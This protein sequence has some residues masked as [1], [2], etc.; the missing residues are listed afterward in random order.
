MDY[1]LGLVGTK[2][3]GKVDELDHETYVASLFHHLF[4]IPLIFKGTYL[5]VADYPTG[6]AGTKIIISW[7]SVLFAYL[8]TLLFIPVIFGILAIIIAL[9]DRSWG[10]FGIALQAIVPAW[11]GFIITY[12]LGEASPVRKRKLRKLLD[13][14]LGHAPVKMQP[15]QAG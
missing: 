2:L 13:E 14:M 3:F 15:D 5:V 11:L 4:G 7:K 9:M 6:F 1:Q 12:K 8:R 10:T